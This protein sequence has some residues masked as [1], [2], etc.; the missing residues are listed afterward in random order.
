MDCDFILTSTCLK[1]HKHLIKREPYREKKTKIFRNVLISKMLAL[2]PMLW[3][4]GVVGSNPVA[5]T[6]EDK[7]LR[8]KQLTLIL[9]GSSFPREPKLLTNLTIQKCPFLSTFVAKT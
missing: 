8:I 2:P 3:E 4:Q 6:N 1:N 5:P 7:P 9:S